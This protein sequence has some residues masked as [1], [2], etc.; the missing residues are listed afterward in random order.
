MSTWIGLWS[1][2]RSQS[3][4]WDPTTFDSDSFWG[5]FH[6]CHFLKRQYFFRPIW[7]GRMAAYVRQVLF[8][9]SFPAISYYYYYFFKFFFLKKYLCNVMWCF[10]IQIFQFGLQ[11]NLPIPTIYF[12]HSF[13]AA[14][15]NPPWFLLS[16]SLSL[17]F[18]FLL[19]PRVLSSFN[20]FNHF[21][22]FNF[23]KSKL[24]KINS[25]PI[26]I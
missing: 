8:A 24:I 5:P 14:M 15:S 20:L 1:E 10:Y 11:Y 7:R 25:L 16:L 9:S 6:T 18:P 19:P 2:I 22:P 21:I 4:K 3:L 17:T 12:T 23:Q 26:H 13:L